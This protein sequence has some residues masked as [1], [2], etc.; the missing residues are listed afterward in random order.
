VTEFTFAGDDLRGWGRHV[1]EWRR[2]RKVKKKRVE[3]NLK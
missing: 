1:S 2:I 3:E